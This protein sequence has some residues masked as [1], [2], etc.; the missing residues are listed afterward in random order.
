VGAGT[1]GTKANPSAPAPLAGTVDA[2]R[3]TLPAGYRFAIAWRHPTLGDGCIGG[4]DTDDALRDAA[5][6]AL[7]ASAATPETTS[8]ENGMRLVRIRRHEASTDIAIVHAAGHR[9]HDGTVLPGEAWLGLA[10]D[11]LAAGLRLGEADARIRT[12]EKSKRLQ[13][14]LYEISD[15]AGSDLEMREML[16]RIHRV[17][18]ELMAADNFFIVQYNPGQDT[19]RFLYFADSRDRFDPDP[20]EDFPLS[21]S[22]LTAALLRHGRPL[23]GPSQAI[24]AE[25]GIPDEEIING[26]QSKD[27][28]GVP[29]L[30]D[31]RVCG[32][33]VV[34][35]YLRP[36]CY[37][38]EE[39]AL[40]EYVGQHILTALDRKTAQVELERRVRS[41]RRTRNCRPK[42]WN[43]S[44]PKSCSRPCSASPICRSAPPGSTNSTPRCTK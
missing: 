29:L 8:D 20:D 1:G 10:A 25:F 42:C 22:F 7:D 32:A 17:V 33:I 18:G 39:Q 14:A 35:D 26:P 27:W 43:A 24:I 11:L 15:L 37:G 16:A 36:D 28:L 6:Q 5:R 34:Q 4:T 40:L 23:I 19:L 41:N 31:G 9:D 38:S 2:L 21:D 44:A 30:R 12:L 3:R 13:Q